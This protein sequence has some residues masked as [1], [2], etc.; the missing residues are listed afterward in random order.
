[1]S[2]TVIDAP[3]RSAAWFQARVGRLCGS[4][5]KDM[6]ATIQKGEAAVRRELRIQLVVER[7]TN[8]PAESDYINDD[9]RRG[10]ELEPDARMAFQI[11]TG[12]LV[13]ETG[14]LSHATLALG[15]SLDGDIEDF[16][17]IVELKVPRSATHWRYLR[18]GSAPSE[19]AAQ[20][21]HNLYVSGAEACWFCSFDPRFP[22]SLQTFVC[23]VERNEQAI[24]EY[25]EKAQRFLDEV[26]REYD[27]ALTCANVGSVLL[28]ASA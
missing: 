16:R 10:I 3:Q 6:L 21:L 7:L 20:I 13:R 28:K 12:L 25:A 15:C 8:L 27:A 17:E 26:Q 19:H 1:M 23:R 5:A 24:A 9:M 22:P 4:R 11:A 2:F 18:E 14:F